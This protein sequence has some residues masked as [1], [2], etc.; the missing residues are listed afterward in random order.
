MNADVKALIA[1]WLDV[2]TDLLRFFNVEA[3]NEIAD[4][5]DAKLAEDAE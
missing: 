3:L 2:L 1:A 4:K 5:I